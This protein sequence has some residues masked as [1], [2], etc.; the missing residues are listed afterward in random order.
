M[1]DW[2]KDNLKDNNNIIGSYD[3]KKDEYNI[4]LPTTDT[5][6]SFTELSRGW[7]S[8][9]SFVPENGISCANE[10]YT[11]K[12]GKVWKHYVE[13]FPETRNTFYGVYNSDSYSTITAVLNDAPGVVKS[14]QALN[15]E[16][17]QSKVDQFTTKTTDDFGNI[18]PATVDGQYYNLGAKEGWYVEYIKTNKQRGTVDEF[19]EKE[20]KWFNYIKGEAVSH[21]LDSSGA[22][23]LNRISID[24]EGN[25][26]WE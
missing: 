18:I 17:S 9:K 14:F 19:I 15:Y 24:L 2:F 22:T 26:N 7:V 12:N 11:F 16:G 5:T 6:V 21:Y 8:F 4:T 25:S 20:G 1:K 13:T 10:Y 23:P 3:D